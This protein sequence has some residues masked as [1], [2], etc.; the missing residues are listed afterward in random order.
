MKKWHAI[1]TSILAS[2]VVAAGLTVASVTPS[3]ANGKSQIFVLYAGSMTAVM[4]NKIRPDLSHHFGIEFQ[5]EG[6]GS[7]ALAQMIKSGISSPDVFISA[8]PSVNTQL[9]MGNNNHNLVKW[10]L[11]LAADQLVIAFSKSSKFY[12]SLVKAE[13]GQIAWYNVLEQKGFR[14][15]RTDPILDPKGVSTLFM[16]ELAQK[17]YHQPNL[18]KKI[19]GT[20]ENTSQ[21]YPEETLLAQLTTGQMDAIV[22]YKHEAVEWH[23]PYITL[24]SAINLGDVKDAKYYAQASYQPPKGK[25]Q[26]GAPILFTITIPAT[27]K[28]EKGAETFVRYLV[29]GAGHKILMQDGFTPVKKQLVGKLSALPKSLRPLI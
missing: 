10:Y 9:L 23:V 24:P 19:L 18:F 7:S 3:L 21:V 14:F 5:G 22:A 2:G 15:G 4:E 25:S 29:A 6:K 13:K 27:V 11:P 8:S 26:K 16:F 12:P 28:N 17:Y 1:S 20:V